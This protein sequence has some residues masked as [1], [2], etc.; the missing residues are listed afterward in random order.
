MLNIC[1]VVLFGI[2]KKHI[3][4][5]HH[6]HCRSE[7]SLLQGVRSAEDICRTASAEGVPAAA[8]TDVNNL[9]GLPAF[10]DAADKYGLKAI[11]AAVITDVITSY[12]IHYT[13]LYEDNFHGNSFV[14]F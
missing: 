1:I 7:Y 3:R 10:R 6:I 5:N 2:M 9:Y 13:K 12:S 4:V 8:V 11:A 14:I